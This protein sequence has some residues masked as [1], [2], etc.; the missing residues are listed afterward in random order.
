[1]ATEASE[2][3]DPFRRAIDN[4]RPESFVGDAGSETVSHVL[5]LVVSIL[6]FVRNRPNSLTVDGSLTKRVGKTQSSEAIL[7]G[8]SGEVVADLKALGKDSSMG[9]IVLGGDVVLLDAEDCCDMCESIDPEEELVDAG[10]VGLGF[11][12]SDSVVLE[13]GL[14]CLEI[15]FVEWK[16]N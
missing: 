6:L 7:F 14:G 3:L 16:E 8:R 5:G 9:A 11:V 10:Y 12:F 1:M 15:W 4:R 13:T 2:E